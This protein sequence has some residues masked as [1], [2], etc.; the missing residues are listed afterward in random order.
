MKY[1]THCL[2]QNPINEN[3]IVRTPQKLN[4]NYYNFQNLNKN[5]QLQLPKIHYV[6]QN[7]THLTTQ[8]IETMLIN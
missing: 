4:I 2:I 6:S 8:K 3:Q 5:I 1:A 7:N